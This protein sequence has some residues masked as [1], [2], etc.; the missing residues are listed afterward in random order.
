MAT[1][2]ATEILNS[3]KNCFDN[4]AEKLCDPKLNWKAYWGILKS[5]S[6]WEK[7]PIT[8]SLLINGRFVTNFNERA[9]RFN[10]FSA[11]QCFLI[12]K[13]QQVTFEQ[14]FY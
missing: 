3:K 6:N 11:N 8:P 4:F 13:Q 1:N 7:V 2:I 9:N 12:N 14:S 5:F 10:D